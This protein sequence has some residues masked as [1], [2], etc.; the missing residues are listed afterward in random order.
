[1]PSEGIE[2]LQFNQYQKFHTAVVIIHADLGY[3][4]GK[5]DGSEK[6]PENSS[7]TKASKFI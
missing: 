7:T 6:N 2:I 5:I 1:M 4:T 3:I